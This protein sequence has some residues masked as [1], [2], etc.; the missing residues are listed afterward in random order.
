[1]DYILVYAP[2]DKTKAVKINETLQ[3]VGLN[4]ELYNKRS[5][6]TIKFFL[7]SYNCS[8]CKEFVEIKNKALVN[9][10]IVI[11]IWL[12]PKQDMYYTRGL[13][14]LLPYQG[15]N[16]HSEYFEERIIELKEELCKK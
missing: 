14:G 9:E 15:L 1:M 3:K 8:E 16:P 13:W 10:E 12:Q 2:K 7:A 11:P 5:E 4:G 6:A